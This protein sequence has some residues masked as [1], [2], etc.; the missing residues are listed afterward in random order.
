MISL[1]VHCTMY[2]IEFI[3]TRY[4]ESYVTSPRVEGT[5]ECDV[6]VCV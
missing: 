3:D 5:T 4:H 2:Y 6:R 1:R